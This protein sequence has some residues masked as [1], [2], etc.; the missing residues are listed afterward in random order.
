LTA[1]SRSPFERYFENDLYPQKGTKE[2]I[3]KENIAGMEEDKS[4]DS[5]IR[6]EFQMEQIRHPNKLR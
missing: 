4:E 3:G 5:E 1:T 2:L 6:G